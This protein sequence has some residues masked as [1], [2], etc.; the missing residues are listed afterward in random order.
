MKSE[1][2]AKLYEAVP[3]FSSL[4]NE[5]LDEIIKAGRLLKAPIDCT[6]L[7][8]GQPGHGLY[9]IVHGMV[10]CRM[11][12]FEGDDAHL[13]NLYKG[14]VF[15]E[16]SL[17]DDC[18]ISASVTTTEESIFYHIEKERFD[19]LRKNLRP[20]AFKVLRALAPT[21]CE[22]LR[23]INIRIGGIFSDPHK[24]LKAMERRYKDTVMANKGRSE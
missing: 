21:I 6:I 12:L 9:I 5:E 15:G 8:E 20:A 2:Y 7:E 18:P 17:I 10:T 14:D 24:H 23:T 13:A 22:R 4:N 16:M 19:S 1:D 11:Q 3:L